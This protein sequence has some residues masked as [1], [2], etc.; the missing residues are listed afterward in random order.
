MQS[1]Y[2]VIVILEQCSFLLKLQFI[3]DS[4][5]NNYQH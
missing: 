4:E 5:Q 3:T 2:E 1:Q